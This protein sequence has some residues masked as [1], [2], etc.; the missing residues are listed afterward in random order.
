MSILRKSIERGRLNRTYRAVPRDQLES[1]LN[2]GLPEH[3]TLWLD[4][5]YNVPDLEPLK[6]ALSSSVLGE[7]KYKA[8]DYNCDNFSVYLHSVLSLEYGC[9]ACGIV[10][11]LKS[12]RVFNIMIAR[13]HGAS[14]VYEYRP[15][16]D[17]LTKVK[18]TE[19]PGYVIK[20]QT[21]LI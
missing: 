10:I 1:I 7:T 16:K 5:K 15:K 8:H 13:D 4:R 14:K 9:N 6:K 3:K 18:E 19:R 12:G 11:S 2:E 21:I 17:K 20:G